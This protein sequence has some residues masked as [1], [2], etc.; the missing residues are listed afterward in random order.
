MSTMLAAPIRLRRW[1]MVIVVVSTVVAGC[2]G[3]A[4]ATPSFLPTPTATS[5]ADSVVADILARQDE[6]SQGNANL[7]PES[8]LTYLG[9][10][11]IPR[12]TVQHKSDPLVVRACR[13]TELPFADK[14]LEH[15]IDFVIERLR[16]EGAGKGIGLLVSAIGLGCKFLVPYLSQRVL[17][18]D[19]SPPPPIAP[20]NSTA[21]VALGEPHPVV[22]GGTLQYSVAVEALDCVKETSKLKAL[23]GYA[24]MAAKVRIASQGNGLQYDA[25]NWDLTTDATNEARFVPTSDQPYS[26]YLSFGKLD[27]GQ[28][29]EGWLLFHVRIPTS[30]IQVI[31][32]GSA[33]TPVPVMIVER[34][35]CSAM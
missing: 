4:S 24:L 18:T 17:E 27:A 19:P 33:T 10:R 21:H 23:P 34:G 22:R 15:G 6:A 8:L 14:V 20:M 35:P 1:A 30:S 16:G 31:Y 12:L 2:G 13:L 7:L 28:S 29:V 25:L 5:I 3:A 11:T 26:P 32:R 9:S